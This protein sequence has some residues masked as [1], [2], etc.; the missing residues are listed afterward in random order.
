MKQFFIFFKKESLE[1][2]RNFRWVWMPLLFILLGLIQPITTYYMPKIIDSLGDLPEGSV[3]EI[4]PPSASDVLFGT[5]SQYFNMIGI[6]V[7]VLAFM[8]SIP[9]ERK[10]GSAALVLVKPVSFRSY[11]LAKWTSALLIVWVSYI[12]GMF[13]NWYYTYQLFALIDVS[14]MLKGLMIYG[15]WLTLVVTLVFFFGSMLKSGGATAALTLALTIIL[16]FVPTLV[17]EKL[18]WFPSKLFQY[19]GE[20]WSNGNI[21]EGTTSAIII[22]FCLIVL[23][24][25]SSLAIF[26]RKEL[27]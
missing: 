10:N 20:L 22:T 17:P 11:V 18:K 13:A 5:V 8:S 26:K 15:V 19:T 12:L 27:I 25:V 2:L 7:I 4:P 1:S 16:S 23:L 3:I 6:L 14:L 24:L 9:G 21:S